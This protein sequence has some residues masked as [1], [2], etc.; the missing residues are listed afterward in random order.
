MADHLPLSSWSAARPSNNSACRYNRAVASNRDISCSVRV[1]E[2][3]CSSVGARRRVQRSD[4]C[5]SRGTGLPRTRILHYAHHQASAMAA[6]DNGS[7]ACARSTLRMRACRLLCGPSQR[8]LPMP[9]HRRRKADLATWC[10][11]STRMRRA[12]VQVAIRSQ[13]GAEPPIE[14]SATGSHAWG[15]GGAS[16]CFPGGRFPGCPRSLGST[17][18]RNIG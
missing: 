5:R 9:G 14:L 18:S 2:W 12:T 11:W 16:A 4:A 17:E 1:R 7:R 8:G 15:R 6:L 10:S 3:V 13:C